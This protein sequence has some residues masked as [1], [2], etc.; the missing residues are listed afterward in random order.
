MLSTGG[1]FLVSGAPLVG[2]LVERSVFRIQISP[3]RWESNQSRTKPTGQLHRVVSASWR[4][5]LER[6]WQKIFPYQRA[7]NLGRFAAAGTE[8]GPLCG[9]AESPPII[10]ASEQFVH[11][12]NDLRLT[13]IKF[14]ELEVR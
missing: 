1:D 6:C 10:V 5:R 8:F 4:V 3:C 11:A 9:E 7:R 12:T 13:D 2:S 14:T